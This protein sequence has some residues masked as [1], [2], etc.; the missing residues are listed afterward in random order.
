MMLR[1][2]NTGIFYRKGDRLI[3]EE[4]PGVYG[5][6][7]VNA[8]DVV[9]DLGAHIGTAS[10]IFLDKG[11]AGTIAVEADPVNIP[12][13]RRNLAGWRSV[14]I[15]AAVGAKA[16]RADFYTRA[17][18][19]YVGSLLPDKGRKRMAV[20]MVPLAGLLKQYRPAILKCDIEFGEYQLPELRSLPDFVRVIAM[21]VHV[22]FIGI[23][24]RGMD[25][26]ELRERREA[27][28]DLIAAIEAQGFV[29]HW[30]KDKQ[31]KEGEPA[32]EPDRSG[33]GP[34]TKCVCVTWV[35]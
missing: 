26:A 25:P 9:L 1:D 2:A 24:N 31:A 4:G 7:P 29:E 15:P 12:Y 3:L 30:R 18:R 32:A 33:L 17:D 28:G 20:A 6:V 35:R 23:F 8:G 13:L 34:M 27:A 19:G 16:G 10:R 14:I 11:A 21:E 5:N 22:R